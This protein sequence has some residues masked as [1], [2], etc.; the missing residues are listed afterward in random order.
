MKF[1]LKVSKS[2]LLE[3]M[4]E[5]F[6]TFILLIAL[7]FSSLILR[8]NE[9]LLVAIV[10]IVLIVVF[11]NFSKGHLNPLFTLSDLFSKIFGNIKD[12]KVIVA[13]LKTAGM[14][15]LAQLL[16]ALAA[17]LVVTRIQSAVVD[18]QI[19]KAGMELT[20]ATKQQ[21]LTQVLYYNTFAATSLK[22]AFFLEALFSF[23]LGLVFLFS[24]YFSKAKTSVAMA[25]G[26]SFFAVEVFTTDISGGSFHMMKSLVAAIFTGGEAWANVWVYLL[27]GILGAAMAGLVFIAFD[28]LSKAVKK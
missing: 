13:E 27:A 19:V 8:G 26:L 14:Y 20:D 1:K 5:F 25:V 12:K 6:G 10:Y 22:L 4:S 28:K 9:P 2:S 23:V 11:S 7:Y 15:L 18:Y 3:V 24:Y 17:Y 16:A 21:V